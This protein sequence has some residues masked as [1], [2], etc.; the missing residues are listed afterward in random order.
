MRVTSVWGAEAVVAR[1]KRFIEDNAHRPIGIPEIAAGARVSPTWL[2]QAFRQRLQMTPMGYLWR[3]RMDGAHTD[4]KAAE[5]TKGDT[6]SEI[7]TR[8]GFA[9]GGRFA[10]QYRK[11]YGCPPSDT[12]RA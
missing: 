8:W 3:V 4:L 5:P 12:L 10:A 6:V 7:A 9:H 11:W 2:G 1:A